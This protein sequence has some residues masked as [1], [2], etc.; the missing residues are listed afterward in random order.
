MGRKIV[1]GRDT[2]G[3]LGVE[4]RWVRHPENSRTRRWTD[5]SLWH[6]R[7]TGDGLALLRYGRDGVVLVFTLAN[8]PQTMFTPNDTCARPGSI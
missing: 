5:L 6:G 3:D 2:E 1:R 4:L 8:L 7:R